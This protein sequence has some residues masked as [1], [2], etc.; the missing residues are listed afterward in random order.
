MED[1][2]RAARSF[3]AEPN[4]YRNE[5]TTLT[6]IVVHGP[7][8]SLSARYKTGKYDYKYFRNGDGTHIREH[9]F[10][11]LKFGKRDMETLIKEGFDIERWDYFK[12]R[13]A[14]REIRV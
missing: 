12:N 9:I 8:G 2:L 3:H 1:H 7:D 10:K 11:T 13:Y 6:V 14:V 5:T 4:D